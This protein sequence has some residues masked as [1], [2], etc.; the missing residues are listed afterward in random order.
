MAWQVEAVL[1]VLGDAELELRPAVVPILCFVDGHWPLFGAP[2][3]FEGVRLESERSI[4][5]VL[6]EPV[7]HSEDEINQIAR[8]LAVAFPPK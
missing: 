3:S 2:S 4:V 7:V 5:S 6:S 8:V 1:E